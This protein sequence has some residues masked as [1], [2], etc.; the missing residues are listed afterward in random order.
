MGLFLSQEEGYNVYAIAWHKW[1]DV[2]VSVVAV[3]WYAFR[4]K[5]RATRQLTITTSV[6][7]L[8]AIILA[9]HQ[10]ANIT[11]G[12]GFLTAPLHPKNEG[13]VVPIADAV[14]FK[15]LVKPILEKK[16]MGCH[17]SKKAKGEL[18]METEEL[19]VKGG[20]NGKLWDVAADLGL[21]MQRIHLPLEDK[22]HM[23][24]IG[25]PQLSDEEKSILK[26]WIKGGAS[27]TKKVSEL[28]DADTLKILALNVLKPSE[29]E[30][31]TFKAGFVAD[32]VRFAQAPNPQY[33]GKGKILFDGKMGNSNFKS[34]K[35]L[36]F[37]ENPMEAY[38]YFNQ[39]ITVSKVI[40]NTLIL[41][42]SY[43]MPAYELQVWGSSNA[44]NLTL[45]KTLSPTQPTK[46]ESFRKKGYELSV[47][48]KQ[49]N[50][51]KLVGKSVQKLLLWHPGKGEKAWFFVDEVFLN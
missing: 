21:M 38:L 19:L 35:W 27:F 24:P 15:D 37:K 31:Y 25:K 49:V 2:A 29:M 44:S 45:L 41:I 34:G 39:L 5:L 3:L 50:V 16:C 51:I 13:N 40:F 17:N 22:K 42:P 46:I 33:S 47:N 18:V 8:V 32:S 9:G 48:P 28:A 6:V 26:Y 1:T 20:K 12:E 4:E 10:G 11:H 23:S 7:S 43:I 30:T 36:G 14:V